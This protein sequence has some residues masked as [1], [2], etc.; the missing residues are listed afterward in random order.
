MVRHDPLP[1][2]GRRDRLSALF[3]RII[4]QGSLPAVAREKLLAGEWR[5]KILMGERLA[6]RGQHP[7]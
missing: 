1:V 7:S 3:E 6:V 2:A 5:Q 4:R